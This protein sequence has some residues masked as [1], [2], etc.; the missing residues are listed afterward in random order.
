VDDIIVFLA[1]AGVEVG[2]VI[3]FELELVALGEDLVSLVSDLEVEGV[4]GRLRF[5]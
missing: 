4:G 5:H 1:G 2:A 3:F